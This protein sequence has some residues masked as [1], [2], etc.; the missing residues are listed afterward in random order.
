M[1]CKHTIKRPLS[2]LAEALISRIYRP[3]SF[4]TNSSGC[5]M[6]LSF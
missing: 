6:L 1:S 4:F 3:I 5:A 2:G